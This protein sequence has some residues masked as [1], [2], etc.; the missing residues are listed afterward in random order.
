MA[1]QQRATYKVLKSKH[2]WLKSAIS[3]TKKGHFDEE[4]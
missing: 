2:N 3:Y 1:R 4:Y